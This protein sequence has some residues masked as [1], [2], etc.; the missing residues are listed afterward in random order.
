MVIAELQHGFFHLE[1]IEIVLH[2]LRGD[3]PEC[4]SC[5]E[6]SARTSGECM[7]SQALSCGAS[8][9]RAGIFDKSPAAI[10]ALEALCSVIL[11]ETVVTVAT[12]MRAATLLF[13]QV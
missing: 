9:P 8:L 3:V 10:F 1:P 6:T 13:Q 7:P 4:S 5:Q 11:A 2:V 12:V